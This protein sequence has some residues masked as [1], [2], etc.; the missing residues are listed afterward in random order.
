M[1]KIQKIQN[2]V[3]DVTEDLDLDL[4][5][6]DFANFANPLHDVELAEGG[7]PDEVV[8]TATTKKDGKK[9]GGKK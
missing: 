7:S 5:T 9:K 3:V 6:E 4:D 8:E 2:A 1:L